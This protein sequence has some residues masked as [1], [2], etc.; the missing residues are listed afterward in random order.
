LCQSASRVKL[1]L[2]LSST[3]KVKDLWTTR[4]GNSILPANYVFIDRCGAVRHAELI[5]SA[6]DSY[7]VIREHALICKP[8]KGRTDFLLLSRALAGA[9]NYKAAVCGD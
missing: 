4:L 6:N 2:G 5:P 1:I 3:S 7:L 9:G 8:R